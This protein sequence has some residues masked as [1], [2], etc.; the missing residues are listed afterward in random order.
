MYKC[1]FNTV[2]IGTSHTCVRIGKL[3]TF[4][5]CLR[6]APYKTCRDMGAKY[7]EFY[8]TALDSDER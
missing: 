1:T 6:T 2:G 3:H 7:H 8:T 4:L 5:V